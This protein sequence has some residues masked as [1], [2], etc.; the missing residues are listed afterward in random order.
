MGLSKQERRGGKSQVNSQTGGPV[1]PGA[2]GRQWELI[3]S[4]N[5]LCVQLA[6]NTER[7]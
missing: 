6:S 1:H 4:L 7:E 2:G 3:G 5:H